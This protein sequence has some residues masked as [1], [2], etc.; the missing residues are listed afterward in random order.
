MNILR[1]VLAVAW[2]GCFGNAIANFFKGNINIGLGVLTIGLFI[3]IFY[4]TSWIV[5]MNERS[6]H[7]G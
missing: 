1:L 5:E 6:K 3:A 7:G 4:I 2:G